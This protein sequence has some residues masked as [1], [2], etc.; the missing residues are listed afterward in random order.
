MESFLLTLV[1]VKATDNVH[2]VPRSFS[3]VA[4]ARYSALL[5]KYV[6][7]QADIGMTVHRVSRVSLLM[8]C[9][10]FGQNHF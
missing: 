5:L 10:R 3:N 9:A 4:Q 2:M 1:N 6:L 8:P 7:L